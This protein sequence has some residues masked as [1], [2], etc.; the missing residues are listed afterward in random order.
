[1]AQSSHLALAP[2]GWVISSVE[3][4]YG[5]RSGES[6]AA[7]DLAC[8]TGRHSRFLASKGFKVL[9]VDKAEPDTSDWPPA[10]TFKQ[11]DLEAGGWPLAGQQFDLIVVTNYLHRD[12]FSQLLACLRPGGAMVYETFMQG[13]E[14][15]G[16]PKNPAF[17]LTPN[18]LLSL[19]QGLN[20][21]GF[22]QGLRGDP[23]S[24]VI[25]RIL[26]VSGDWS[27]IQSQSKLNQHR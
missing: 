8:G 17:L 3:R 2:S 20:V 22:E 27:E 25:Q 15:Y 7:L 19:C 16:S 12:T 1:M 4:L 18:E 6:R 9:A 11:M 21:L 10:I 23:A 5:A 14:A 24:A 26:A 13:N